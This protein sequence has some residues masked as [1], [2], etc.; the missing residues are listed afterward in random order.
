ML[1]HGSTCTSDVLFHVGP[2]LCF[3]IELLD[4][5]AEPPMVLSSLVRADGDFCLHFCGSSK[6]DS[7]QFKHLRD[8][9][10][11]YTGIGVVLDKDEAI[12]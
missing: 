1:R 10:W 9:L 7:G 5:L 6:E 2:L 3:R 8:L 12:S 11:R 4:T